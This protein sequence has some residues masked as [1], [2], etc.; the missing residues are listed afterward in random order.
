MKIKNIILFSGLLLLG[1]N[2][3]KD[4]EREVD[5]EAETLEMQEENFEENVEELRQRNATVDAIEGNPELSTFATGLNVWNVED[6]L[7]QVTG[8]YMVF[9]PSNRAYSLVYR[10]QGYDILTTTP[11]AVIPYHIVKAD[12]TMDE[13]RS[14]IQ[15]ANGSLVL[16]T[17]EGENITFTM[18]G[19]KI[20]LTGTT[21]LKA[22]ITESFE[23]ANGTAYIID[24]VL[25]PEG[26][27]TVTIT[28][29][30]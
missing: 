24:S 26:I 6:T 18:E 12:Y 16:P 11:E 10:Q 13:L 4:N 7:D 8:S 27:A 19:D 28:T 1:F 25:M 29:E 17:F 14:E 20:V 5:T 21:G 9:A 30:E 2:S 23:I 22:N 15:N 3:C